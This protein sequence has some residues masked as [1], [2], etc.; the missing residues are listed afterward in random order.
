MASK[1]P[2]KY[3]SFTVKQDKIVNLI[4]GKEVVIQ[5]GDDILASHIND[6]QDNMI[7]IE[8][9]LGLI[10][11]GNFSSVADRL[12]DLSNGHKLSVPSI[13][14]YTDNAKDINNYNSSILAAEFIKGFNVAVIG[15]ESID[16]S[17]ISLST[18][19][20][21]A[22]SVKTYT[23]LYI[24]IDC[25]EA[26]ISMQDINNKIYTISRIPVAGIFL[27]NFGY[28]NILN[29]T[30]QNSIINSIHALNLKIITSST[31]PDNVLSSSYVVTSNQNYTKI[32]LGTGDS[33]LI[34]DFVK[35]DSLLTPLTT[36]HSNALKLLSYK[37]ILG[38]DIFASSYISNSNVN[39]QDEFFLLSAFCMLY[40]FKGVNG[41]TEFNNIYKTKY[42]SIPLTG[43]YMSDNITVKVDS[44]KT[45]YSRI[46]DV[47]LIKIYSENG[48]YK[49]DFPDIKIPGLFIDSY[50]MKLDFSKLDFSSFKIDTSVITTG[51]LNKDRYSNSVIAAINSAPVDQLIPMDR[52]DQT[53]N[54]YVLDKIKSTLPVFD[55]DKTLL[56]KE[57]YMSKKLHTLGI[58]ATEN[59]V[60]S[61]ENKG[62]SV[63]G[64][65]FVSSPTGVFD[66]LHVNGTLYAARINAAKF[67][68][69][70]VFTPS[71]NIQMLNNM[72]K[73]SSSEGLNKI[74]VQVFHDDHTEPTA[75]TP[76]IL[77]GM[78]PLNDYASVGVDNDGIQE[79]ESLYINEQTGATVAA[80]YLAGS[81]I[82]YSTT[83]RSKD[84]FSLPLT[85][86]KSN[87]Q[88][89]ATVYLD[90]KLVDTIGTD[91]MFKQVYLPLISQDIKPDGLELVIISES[92][93]AIDPSIKLSPN[94]LSVIDDPTDLTQYTIS[95]SIARVDC[96]SNKSTKITGDLIETGTVKA[97]HME[98]GTITAE[99]AIIAKAAIGS[100][101]IQNEAVGN[102]HIQKLAVMSA[103]IDNAAVTNAKIDRASINKLVVIS[104]DIKDAA[105]GNAKIDRA[106]VNKLVVIS[107]DI[108][109]ANILSVHI[110]D[111]AITNAK[112]D[113]LS[114][115]KLTVISAD[116]LDAAITNAKIDRASINKLVVVSA[117]I[118][119]ANILSAHILD[120]AITNAKIDRASVN[121]LIVMTADIAYA[122]IGDA[123]IDRATVNK[124]VV[125]SADIK[126]STIEN[127]KIK[128]ATIESAKIKFLD[129]DKITANSITTAQ[130]DATIIATLGDVGTIKTQ[131]SV[132]QGQ[133]NLLATSET[134]EGLNYRLSSA[135][136]KI[137]PEHIVLTVT[138]SST[139]IDALTGKA[140][141][142]GPD[143]VSLIEQSA[144]DIGLSASRIKLVGDVTFASWLD[145]ND[146]TRID[147]SKLYTGS[148]FA[149]SI[150]TD[151]L[152]AKMITSQNAYIQNMFATFVNTLKI[153][154]TEGSIQTMNVGTLNG[155]KISLRAGTYEYEY[156]NK[157]N[158]IK[159]INKNS[160]LQVAKYERNTNNLINFYNSASSLVSFIEVTLVNN[161]Y[162]VNHPIVGLKSNATI[163][164][165]ELILGYGIFHS[166]E[167]KLYVLSE[168]GSPKNTISDT[169]P[170]LTI[171]EDGLTSSNSSG[172]LVRVDREGLRVSNNNG[173]TWVTKITADGLIVHDADIKDLTAEKINAGQL[174]AS[175]ASIAGGDVL[176]D[177]LGITING[178]TGKGL[179]IVTA[180]S[181][182]ITL[183]K[184]GLQSPN[185]KVNS[186]GTAVFSGKVT[187]SSGSIGG[188]SLLGTT[189]N[190][191]NILLD[192]TPGYEKITLG[193]LNNISLKSDG[194]A[195]IGALNVVS[196]GTVFTG[197]SLDTYLLKIDNTGKLWTNSAEI[198]GWVVN[199]TSISKTN[200]A[201]VL[202]L[203]SLNTKITVTNG[204]NSIV[205]DGSNG[206]LTA[207]NVDLKGI[208]TASS[209]KIGG[210]NI[211]ATSLYSTDNIVVLDQSEELI[212][213]R[214]KATT[215]IV[216]VQIGKYD[217][218][219]GYEK[220]GLKA[221]NTIIDSTG[222]VAT[223]GKIANWTLS[224]YKLTAGAISIDAT[225]GYEKISI[226][227]GIVL[228]TN[229]SAT[230]GELSLLSDG[231]LYT[232]A[233]YSA[234]SFKVDTTGKIWTNSADIGGWSVVSGSISRTSGN[235]LLNLDATNNK[236]VVKNSTNTITL[237][238]VTG[239]LTANSVDL[240][241][242]IT[243]TSGK[244]GSWNVG[245]TLYSTN[246]VVTL[247]PTN[248][249]L[250]IKNS[251][252][253]TQVLLGKYDATVGSE[254]YGLKAGSTIIDASGIIASSG[255]I[256]NWI[257]ETSKMTSGNITIDGT[258]GSEKISLIKD[259]N[260]SIILDGTTGK[261]TANNVSITGNVTSTSGFVGGW[262]ITSNLI[263]KGSINLDATNNAIWIGSTYDT[264]NISLN[265]DGSAKLGK[266]IIS[267]DG[268]ISS[269]SNFEIN[270][271]GDASFN[272][273]I[274]STLG[275]IGGWA[276]SSTNLSGG[277]VSINS[278]GS[279]SLGS[280]NQI[281][282]DSISGINVGGDA[283]SVGLLGEV[284]AKN[285]VI[286][287]D[288]T[289]TSGTFNGAIHAV[290]GYFGSETDGVVIN[291]KSLEVIGNSGAIR[292]KDTFNHV[293]VEMGSTGLTVNNG[294]IKLGPIDNGKYNFFADNSGISA[295][296][297]NLGG[298]ILTPN[299]I[300]SGNITLDSTS[301]SENISIGTNVLFNSNGSAKIGVLSID[302]FGA[303]SSTNFGIDK[304]G[305]ATFNGS[306]TSTSGKI[307]GWDLS[308][309]GLSSG[310]VQINSSGNIKLGSTQQLVLD[311]NSGIIVGSG[312]TQFSVDLLG[313]LIAK[314][315]NISGT[316]NATSGFFGDITNKITVDTKGLLLGTGRITDSDT[317]PIIKID[318]TGIVAKAGTIGSIIL[319]SNGLTAG[320]TRVTDQGIKVQGQKAIVIDDGSMIV[321][322]EAGFEALNI[323]NN[324]GSYGITVYGSVVTTTPK[325]SQT[326][327][328][329]VFNYAIATEAIDRPK[330]NKIRITMAL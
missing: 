87:I 161:L 86:Y 90:G 201:K 96:F 279:I 152:S 111:A 180:N 323:G 171:D 130:F 302:T 270:A 28:S 269:G 257:L 108:A 144:S 181:K 145:P 8:N 3:D 135:E 276:I 101:E 26:N 53:N 222:I 150:D 277:D 132:Q 291:G 262:K 194:S 271:A 187:A 274:T 223:S 11:N 213:I 298:W 228:N 166:N 44:T 315:A 287:G 159:D 104:A 54:N 198:G 329:A 318:S 319:D 178:V 126:D 121:K 254:K 106:S 221:G 265:N 235:T 91:L 284:V 237:D 63:T 138:Q 294:Q 313:N 1:Y 110:Q 69:S 40:G 71:G 81:I 119:E 100:A 190:A 280:T 99:S 230:L 196:D 185:F 193:S 197:G 102:S 140:N 105:I 114:A 234:Y 320:G 50:G 160:I 2:F 16:N 256:A 326:A 32:N 226:G 72:L 79:F 272:G 139:Y 169:V 158:L 311:A 301:G 151:S 64:G 149:D 46:T 263:S 227:T 245:T 316:I 73:I 214:D 219:V 172:R 179:T 133:I 182:I 94:L 200:G 45:I 305:A 206:K 65:G 56:E 52:L 205:L 203:D 142:N 127:A 131:L 85:I 122:A 136:E 300:K 95:S 116:I 288:I 273:S 33:F 239:V 286:I 325:V 264:S 134:V 192:A 321:K 292:V 5:V 289:A 258:T 143:L 141:S 35:S 285:A 176:I 37:S 252:T 74:Y 163:E 155:E 62:L 278:T 296:A 6:I 17:E 83:I 78:I 147:G 123:Q 290:S 293:M 299:N 207:D 128:D 208:I 173:V 4:D 89:I 199:S 49:Y 275:T 88:G 76:K 266:L 244:I 317:N 103:Q 146:K 195:I 43:N 268:G 215:P 129:G 107:A 188:W 14:I 249:L 295:N 75:Y 67:V 281:V 156:D 229:G 308:A 240:T 191:G 310:N 27:D 124:L 261:F 36:L 184:D 84:T 282:L 29:R 120:A 170:N 260:N 93:H 322:N 61:G 164:G 327:N 330:L 251:S 312:T 218:T 30:N 97:K 60:I 125:V 165:L 186:D 232:G 225:L 41:S 162:T 109:E 210:W 82:S 204:T 59:I 47:G 248:E 113:R 242:K 9:T 217:N 259:I 168:P 246:N 98:T 202:T 22:N 189:L 324:N 77:S 20:Y 247:D 255:K 243:A 25:S 253:V 12:V 154:A 10:P 21:I 38:I 174:D 31:N 48:I 137:T 220:Y 115:D 175:K 267:T 24:Y 58:D 7:S 212:T 80:Q 13:M 51:T 306:L 224:T 304:L 57:L 303:I 314:S 216:Q 157:G 112:I 15:L 250:T 177:G 211:G 92:N 70:P 307:G 55:Y 328:E 167:S 34:K 209:G 231:T 153:T 117:D 39:Q 42:S 233:S 19:Y 23:D 297:G 309:T 283:F 18:A 241:G 66:I 148:V 118:A 238:G 183:N 236:I 68:G